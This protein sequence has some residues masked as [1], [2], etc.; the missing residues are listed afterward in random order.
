[1]KNKETIYIS[2]WKHTGKSVISDDSPKRVSIKMMETNPSK[3]IYQSNLDAYG[4][5]IE[6]KEN[7]LLFT[8]TQGGQQIKTISLE[9]FLKRL[10]D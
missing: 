6:Q 5:I 2:I 9:E 3:T 7:E 4:L 8:I 1:M 10:I